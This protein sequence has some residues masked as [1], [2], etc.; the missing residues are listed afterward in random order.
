MGEVSF[1]L[2]HP[3]YKYPVLP[4]AT[5][6]EVGGFVAD[7]NVTAGDEGRVSHIHVHGPRG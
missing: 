6:E 7:L 3:V 2:E 5:H 4:E 1:S